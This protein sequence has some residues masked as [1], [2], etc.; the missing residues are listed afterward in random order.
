MEKLS[1]VYIEDKHQQWMP[2]NCILIQDKALRLFKD[3]K[4]TWWECCWCYI[5][6]NSRMVS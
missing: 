5:Q 2:I 6:H 4:Q 1:S 3:L